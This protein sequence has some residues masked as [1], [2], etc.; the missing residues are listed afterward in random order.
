[1]VCPCAAKGEVGVC[2]SDINPLFVLT[3]YGPEAKP[4]SSAS[5]GFSSC[6]WSNTGKVRITR[7]H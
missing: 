6:L 2:M 5:P 7:G 1:M 3:A 4:L